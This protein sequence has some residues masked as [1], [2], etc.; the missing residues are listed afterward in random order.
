MNDVV[1]SCVSKPARYLGGEPGSFI[2]K[3]KAKVRW[4]L[5]FPDLYDIG[6]SHLGL[7]ILY[8]ILN[9]L[10]TVS[11]ERVFAPW[12]DYEQE[13]RTHKGRLRSLESHS[14]LSDFDIV[15]FTLQ[16]EML[17]SNV[18]NMLDL[19]AI[20]LH[21][22]ERG[23]KDPLVIAGGPCSV[24]PEP[25]ADFIDA[26][27]IGD[28][29]AAVVTISE[30]LEQ[31]KAKSLDR[32]ATLDRLARIP[33]VYVPR[34]YQPSW[35]ADGTLSALQ[36]LGD[37][38][39]RV[40]SLKC[41]I[42]GLPYPTDQVIPLVDSVHDRA[43]IEIRRGCTRSCRFCQAGYISRPVR[44]RDVAEIAH[45]SRKT[46]E[47]TG[48]D[49]VSL[50]SLSSGDYSQVIPLLNLLQ[51][52][53]MPVR[54]HVVVPSLRLDRVPVSFLNG[55]SS[56]KQTSITF[57]PEAGSL[58]LRKAINKDLSDE[59]IFS[60]VQRTFDS[61]WRT[62]KLYFMVGLPTETE[63]D[64]EAIVEMVRT[65][66]GLLKQGE[67]GHKSR[68]L[69]ISV[70]PFV[71]K[72]HTP[73]QWVPQMPL[74]EIQT[75]I[76]YLAG[77]LR[78]SNVK[79]HWHDLR[80]SLIEAVLTRGD[81]NL[82]KVLLEAWRLGVKM[83]DWTD[84]FQP[85]I[86]DKAF[87]ITG[88]QPSF[89]AQRKRDQA[90]VFPWDIID[91]GV[92]RQYL[93]S[94]HEK[95][96]HGE[97]TDDCFH[98]E[99]SGC[100]AC[101]AELRTDKASAPAEVPGSEE[102]TADTSSGQSDLLDQPPFWFRVQFAKG[103]RSRFLSHLELQR[104]L[105]QSLHRSRLPLRMTQGFNPRPRLS[106][107]LATP[108]GIVSHAEYLDIAM[109]SSVE[110]AEVLRRLQKAWGGVFR[111]KAVRYLGRK[112][113]PLT[114]DSGG[115]LYRVKFDR[116]LPSDLLSILIQSKPAVSENGSSGASQSS[117]DH[118]GETQ[119]VLPDIGGDDPY[120]KALPHSSTKRPIGNDL[121]AL[122][123]IDSIDMIYSLPVQERTEL[124][125]FVRVRNGRTPKARDLLAF[126]LL[127]LNGFEGNATIEKVEILSQTSQGDWVSLMDVSLPDAGEVVVA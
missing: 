55:L 56:V 6:M 70:A 51:S 23:K 125:M 65:L 118:S 30:A 7:K 79:V 113:Q 42:K 33:G 124:E 24:N 27:V 59:E 38:P 22:S 50:M 46:L 114:T 99:C 86:W 117:D 84:C 89:Y 96:F 49:E 76:T 14:P 91:V 37:Y 94:E 11:C 9:G 77:R 112:H 121:P 60:T 88:I 67:K 122:D 45:L 72:P 48:F 36:P 102:E 44:E 106:L 115:I 71:P 83:D 126:V 95:A 41:L 4:A 39:K 69:S 25:L 52:E 26:F 16:H 103:E 105:I 104:F 119:G 109:V 13:L 78:K 47:S 28:G 53:L 100:G 127:L 66:R 34:F 54:G 58:R 82:G 57:A 61:G 64:L 18:I 120:N 85:D 31:C 75:K 116:T 74:E 101:S 107:G 8:A 35:N 19:A 12:V 21:S 3:P 87:E 29:E 15:G 92:S 40:K 20:P 110:A 81:R 123:I 108:V 98:S 73:F 93:W 68:T 1:L 62:V 2:P 10:P 17:Y 111:I 32:D 63:D 90:E 97:I 5:A 80:K 43:S